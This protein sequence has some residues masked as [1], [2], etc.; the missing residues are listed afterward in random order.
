NKM[1]EVLFVREA[2]DL[3]LATR[4]LAQSSSASRVTGRTSRILLPVGQACPCIGLTQPGNGHFLDGRFERHTASSRI[5]L[6]MTGHPVSGRQAVMAIPGPSFRQR[7]VGTLSYPRRKV[8]ADGP[9]GAGAGNAL[10]AGC[11]WLWSCGSA[12]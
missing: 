11:A 6:V 1:R 5:V 4:H 9:T 10:G 8:S 7:R 2:D 12:G 3:T